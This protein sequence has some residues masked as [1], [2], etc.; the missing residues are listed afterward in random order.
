M[1]GVSKRRRHQRRETRS[2]L[3]G[4][5]LTDPYRRTSQTHKMS[6]EQESS[7]HSEMSSQ[8]QKAEDLRILHRI[9]IRNALKALD[10]L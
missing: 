10:D 3:R 1:V 6:N 9:V 4:G 5:M 2:N 7:T 8:K